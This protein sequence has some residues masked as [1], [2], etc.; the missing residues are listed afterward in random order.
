MTAWR[1]T[2]CRSGAGAR[3]TRPMACCCCSNAVDDA[4]GYA[5]AYQRALRALEPPLPARAGLHFGPVTLRANE[6]DDVARG[7]KPLEVEGIAKAVAGRVMSVALGGQI[8]LTAAA[9]SALSAQPWR[10]QSHGHWRL[11]GLAEPVELFEVGDDA[12]PFVPPPDAEKAYRVAQ[13]GDLWQ[14]MREIAAQPAGRARRLRRSHAAAGRAGAPPT[15]RRAAGVGARR[16][17]RRQDTAGDALRPR[18]D[19]RVPGRRLVL[20]PVGRARPRRPAACGRAGPRRRA[21]PRRPGAAAGARDRRAVA[22]AC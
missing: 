7:A 19:R 11:K 20:R 8:L 1:A 3:S 15:G 9:R 14:P 2:C 12:A 16:R 5:L 18:L 10:L 4:V 13:Q 17:W 6:P 22:A 21:R